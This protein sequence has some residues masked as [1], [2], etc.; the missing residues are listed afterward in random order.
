MNV[1]RLLCAQL[2][3]AIWNPA[4]WD[5]YPLPKRAIRLKLKY[6]AMGIVLHDRE[7]NGEVR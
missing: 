7:L 4:A 2:V 3:L 5:F 6:R 1:Q